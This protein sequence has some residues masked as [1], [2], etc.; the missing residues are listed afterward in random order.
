MLKKLA[1]V[2]IL[3]LGL[4]L[5]HSSLTN[6]EAP[7]YVGNEGCNCH[8]TEMA[9]WAK[10]SHGAAFDQLLNKKR[11]RAQHKALKNLGF[12]Y[13][14]DY[15]K[16]EKCLA[17]HTTGYGQPGGYSL[18]NEKDDLKGA[19]CETCHGPGSLYRVLHKEKDET[20]T[21]EEAAALGE[22]YPPS[23]EMCR[24][25]HDNENSVFSSK[26]DPKYGFNFKERLEEKKSWHKKYDLLFEH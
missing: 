26:S 17:C 12:D 11:S 4:V 5:A 22:V 3:C 20:F 16:D 14:K 9:D 21:K 8:K 18:S 24:K 7:Q 1:A 6:A 23:E 2:W 15:D 25:C 19:G 13:K 10:S